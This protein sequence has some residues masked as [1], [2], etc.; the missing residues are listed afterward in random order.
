[1]HAD[2]VTSS[3]DSA[4]AAAA[5][6]RA[7]ASTDDP[8]ALRMTA[9]VKTFSGVMAL[10]SVSF[11]ARAG[12]VHAIVGENGA[13]KSTLMAIAA[14]DLE[15]DAGSIEIVGQPVKTFSS[16]VAS[17]MGLALV[18]QHPSL[19]PDLTV[20]ENFLL[21]LPQTARPSIG[22][23]G[24]WTRERLAS[25]AST[26]NPSTRVADLSLADQHLIEFVK[27]LATDPKVLILD[28]PTEHMDREQVQQ[29]F[30]GIR[31]LVAQ[32]CAVIYISHRIHEVKAIADRITV[33]R[34]GVACA[35]FDAG[36]VSE[37]EIINL[38]VGRTLDTAFPAKL[39][40]C[41]QPGA[42][43]LEIRDLSGPGFNS[44][45]V[46]TWRG[47][48]VGLA[49]IEGNGQRDF[50]RGI[51][52]LLPTSGHIAIG[53]A[54]QGAHPSRGIAYIPRERHREGLLTSLSVGKNM[55]LMALVR[56]ASGGFLSRRREGKAIAARVDA[57]SIKTP[58]PDALVKN[59]SGGNQQKVVIARCLMS[60]PSVLLADEPSQGVDAGARFEIYSIL[61]KEAAEGTSVIVASADALE[62]AG[63]CDRVL[64]FSR[65]TVVKELSGDE[66]TEHNITEAALTSTAL[67]QVEHD[68][69]GGGWLRS[70]VRSDYTPSAILLLAAL[71][72]GVYA[73]MDSP[74]YLTSRNF[75]NVLALLAPLVFISLGQMVV[76]L[77]AGIDLS[78]GPL[79]GVTV[80]ICS[81]FVLDGVGP[82]TMA[83]GLALA[84]LISVI[85]GGL[86]WFLIRKTLIT[87]VV[88]TL[89]TFMSIRGV[90]L[91][92]RNVPEGLIN[93]DVSDWLSAKIGFVPIAFIAAAA[94]IAVLEL[95]LR[96]TRWGIALRAVGSSEIN[97][98]RAGVPVEWAYLSA[99]VLCASLSYAG[100]ILL[101]AQIG[102][103]D[104]TAGV[105]Y[106]LTS[107]TAVVLGG[108]SLS[109]GR[110]SFVGAFMGAALIQQSLNVTTFIKLNPAWQYWLIG[111]LI[112][113]AALLYS[114]LRWSH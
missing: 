24:A 100:G 81:F 88:A 46:K 90:S 87:P 30:V 80:V 25:W 83:F 64:I 61:R 71:A 13:G 16:A 22:K 95:A 26:I 41:L 93:S 19:L 74:F 86:N 92:L 111:I 11:S 76:M 97:A 43:L 60:E 84:L 66:V 107:I 6:R 15:P 109:G 37:A 50:L 44:V 35:V 2:I 94:T 101:M 38:V 79:A 5:D 4:V 42:P 110:G 17:Q 27:A 28:E 59:L 57:L 108:A 54:N 69:N 40:T 18:H 39:K 10:R 82:G 78:V 56:H 112:L 36:S 105:S 47:E 9:V 96:R 98:R 21:A 33:M 103:G 12:E 70:F 45:S 99:Y 73:S 91:W 1:V 29:L 67:R 106:T 62:L 32:G 72:L 113:G 68:R 14:G 85:V 48:I 7:T 8:S 55:G 114:R 89:A 51:A 31:A 75:S 23:A 102:V 63:L 53:A 34:D 20:S 58:G 52:G 65:G 3:A 49:G 104:P 77:A